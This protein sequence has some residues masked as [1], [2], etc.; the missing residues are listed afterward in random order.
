MTNQLIDNFYALSLILIK[1]CSFQVSCQFNAKSGAIDQLTLG[2]RPVD[3]DRLVGHP[4]PRGKKRIH[5]RLLFD[6]KFQS[7]VVLVHQCLC[8]SRLVCS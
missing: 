6:T 4:W 7:T 8:V 3:C 2:D 5:N 1:K